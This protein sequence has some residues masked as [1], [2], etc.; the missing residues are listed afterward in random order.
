[1]PGEKILA[2]IT[3]QGK[4]L[5]HK[6]NCKQAKTGGLD[7]L[8]Y[9]LIINDIGSRFASQIQLLIANEPG[10]FAKLSGVM[11]EKGINIIELTQASYT[12]EMAD[13]SARIGVKTLSEVEDLISLFHKKDFIKKAILL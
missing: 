9:I 3:R 8:T 5:I 4:L 2:C 11:G 7:N 10:T 6:S 12:E 1:M 13:V